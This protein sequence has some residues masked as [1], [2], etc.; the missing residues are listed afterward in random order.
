[1]PKPL[2]FRLTLGAAMLLVAVSAVVVRAF[3]PINATEAI[4][5]ASDYLKNEHGVHY[6]EM[7]VSVAPRTSGS[8]WLVT[9]NG[10]AWL[11][12]VVSDGSIA[13][14]ARGF[15]PH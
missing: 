14:C 2:R 10:G 4:R 3:M 11:V 12:E 15:C 7:P 8:G 5:V 1:M 9:F 6:D 13:S